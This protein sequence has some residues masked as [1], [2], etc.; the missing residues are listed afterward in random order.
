M[1]YLS[2]YLVILTCKLELQLANR[3]EYDASLRRSYGSILILFNKKEINRII[4]IG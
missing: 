4:N 2:R 1:T 3:E